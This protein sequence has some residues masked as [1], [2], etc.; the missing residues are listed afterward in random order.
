MGVKRL[1]IKDELHYRSGRTMHHCSDCNHFV[2][3]EQPIPG[4]L[5]GDPR[6]SV[7]GL[8]PGRQYRIKKESNSM[9]MEGIEC[10]A[11]YAMNA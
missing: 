10:S 5:F 6:C 4:K 2:A 11:R 1:K 7:I 3:G 9:N 8:K